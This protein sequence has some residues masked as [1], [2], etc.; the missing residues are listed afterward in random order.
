MKDE[1]P[2][3]NEGLLIKPELMIVVSSHGKTNYEIGDEIEV[4][5][6]SGVKEGSLKIDR[7][8]EKRGI[9]KLYNESGVVIKAK[10]I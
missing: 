6:G 7:Y 3:V 10:R 9:V 2:L 8:D 5:L 1:L 4:N